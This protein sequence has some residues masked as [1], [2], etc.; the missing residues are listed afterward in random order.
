MKVAVAKY[1]MNA[2]P[3]RPK[4]QEDHFISEIFRHP[5]YT[6]LSSQEKEVLLE[7]LTKNNIED[8]KRKPFDDFFPSHSFKETL[9]GKR[10]LDLGCGIG[11]TTIAMGEKWEVSEFY[12]ID[13]NAE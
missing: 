3:N 2:F 11:G 8:A 5:N 13:V 7:K 12:G 4:Y 9:K 10:V 1:I 6:S